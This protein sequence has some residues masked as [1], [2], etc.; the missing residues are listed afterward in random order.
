MILILLIKKQFIITIENLNLKG[1]VIAC[2]KDMLPPIKLKRNSLHLD[3]F[4]DDKNRICQVLTWHHPKDRRLSIV[5]YDLGESHWTSRETGLRYKRL[6]KSY[7]LEGHQDNL[8]NIK[9]VEPSYLY[10][11]EMYDVEFLAVPMERITHYYYPE[12]R[13]DEILNSENNDDI[14]LKVKKLAELMHDYLHIPFENMGITGSIVWE[15]QTEKSDIDF[16]IYGNEFTKDFN[17][18]FTTIYD[19]FPKIKPLT[20]EKQKRYVNSLARK[21]GLSLEMAKKYVKMKKWLSVFD[22]TD[23]SLIFSPTSSELPFNYGD[24][25]FQP[26]DIINI[27]CIITDS[28]MGFAYPAIYKIKDYQIFDDYNLPE[29]LPITRVLSFEGALTGF[30]VDGDEVVVRALLEKV[31]DNKNNK[32]FYQII[33][34]TKECQGNEF[35][36]F[37]EDYQHINK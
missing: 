33:L 11:S 16:M 29:E 17:E 9:Q 37:I 32:I 8:E 3:Y 14:E 2:V 20:V 7:S 12:Y 5:K 1:K 35:I 24:Q 15:G 36:I 25:I 30:F 10:H 4:R 19:V 18:K 23:L 34:G 26:I 13:L 21:S 31:I 22:T 27:K 28:S 6:L